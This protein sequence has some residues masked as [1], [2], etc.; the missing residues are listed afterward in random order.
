MNIAH[1]GGS[2]GAWLKDCA[3]EAVVHV[4]Q[5]EAMPATGQNHD[6]E[7]GAWLATGQHMILNTAR[8][9]HW[10]ETPVAAM[11]HVEWDSTPSR[12]RTGRGAIMHR[13]GRWRACVV[14]LVAVR[15]GRA[16][17]EPIYGGVCACESTESQHQEQYALHESTRPQIY[18][19]LSALDPHTCEAH[20]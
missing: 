16:A 10:G 7:S 2:W 3:H 18:H 6:E 13:P 9:L 5:T 11:G 19:I 15:R 17:A 8:F 12:T 1:A 14:T 20:H 4:A